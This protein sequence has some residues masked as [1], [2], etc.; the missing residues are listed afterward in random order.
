MTMT[1][2]EAKAVYDVLVEECG[3]T[4]ILNDPYARNNF[5]SSVTQDGFT[6]YRFIGKLGFG[7]KFWDS[8]G[9]WYVS[10]YPEDR[11]A[12]RNTMIATANVRLE[13]MREAFRSVN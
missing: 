2:E 6:E 5:Q 1:N 9:K 13:A 11:T 4:S 10:C 7:G 12:E 8:H 3:A